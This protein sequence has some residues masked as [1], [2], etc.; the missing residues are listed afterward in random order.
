MLVRLRQRLNSL[1][2]ECLFNISLRI[3]HLQGDGAFLCLA[4]YDDHELAGEE[5]HLWLGEWFERGSI[6]IAGSLEGACACY[7]E[8]QFIGGKRT[9]VAVLVEETHGDKSQVVAIS[10]E[11]GAVLHVASLHHTSHAGIRIVWAFGNEPYLGRLTSGVL[12]VLAYLVAILVVGNHTNLAW[13]IL[14]VV[15]TKAITV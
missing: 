14:Y 4:L 2:L 12:H 5:L 9:F 13:L 1:Q 10:L 7:L 11:T 3:L 6:A 8:G 15:P